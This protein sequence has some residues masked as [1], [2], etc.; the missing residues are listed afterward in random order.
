[1]KITLWGDLNDDRAGDDKQT[2]LDLAGAWIPAKRPNFQLDGGVN[3]GLNSRTP[4]AQI[5]VGVSRR[6]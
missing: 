2:T 6:F 5:Y 3:L 4:G 1:M